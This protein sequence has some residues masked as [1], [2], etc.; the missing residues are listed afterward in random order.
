MVNIKVAGNI[1]K[2]VSQN[3][4]SSKLALTEL[5]KNS[6]EAGASFVNIEINQLKAITITDDGC[7]MNSEGIDSLLHI[8]Q[9]N[10]EFGTKVHGRYVSGEKGIGFFS[11][12]KFG[13]KVTVKTYNN[14]TSE[15]GKLCLKMEEIKNQQNITDLDVPVTFT[16]CSKFKG[17]KIII[18]DLCNET[19]DILINN[20]KDEG[21][22]TRLANIINDKNF[23][24]TISVNGKTVTNDIYPSPKFNTAKIANIKYLS[25]NDRGEYSNEYYITYNDTKYN[26]QIS[27]EYKNILTLSGFK[28]DIDISIYSLKS[29]KAKYAPKLYYFNNQKRISPILYINNSIFEDNHIYNV[30]SNAP[31]KSSFVFR[32]QIGK[33]LIFL[34]SDNILTFNSD[35]TKIIESKNYISLVNF[36]NYLSSSVQ[37]NLRNIINH[38]EPKDNK[39]TKNEPYARFK[40]AEV[41]TQEFYKFDDLFCLRDSNNT[42][43]IKPED[44]KIEPKLSVSI[45]KTNR[46]VCFMKEDTYTCTILFSDKETGIPKEITDKIIARSNVHISSSKKRYIHSFLNES[47][48]L[49]DIITEFRNQLNRVYLSQNLNIVFVSSLRTFVELVIRETLN[50]VNKKS[51]LNLADKKINDETSLKKL[52][53]LL[54][55][56]ENV[57]SY[58]KSK[59]T[60][61][62]EKNAF[63]NG[64]NSF[65][66][67]NNLI[68]YLNTYTH[69]GTKV[70]NKNETEYLETRINF[71]FSCLNIAY[72]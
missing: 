20:L 57:I 47:D 69:S 25:R 9:S 45:N 49:D 2:E 64:F 7:G 26:Y 32:Q 51:N 28:I 8:S 27:S 22:S 35:R 68:D 52:L 71:L 14:E 16:K 48:N 40:K 70:L 42:N 60:N 36:T 56:D 43:K 59:L 29:V 30:E 4:T 65:H 21:E 37:T 11:V 39:E 62:N 5:I 58:L 6:Y 24:I 72:R 63:T 67:D 54:I 38:E 10:K 31:K 17:T 55:N 23:K 33:I 41:A 50:L 44:L 34:D 13:N 3:I 53:N 19:V 18:E 1:I 66:L 15:I 46:T 12:F 61:N